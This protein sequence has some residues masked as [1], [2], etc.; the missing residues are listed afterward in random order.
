MFPNIN[1]NDSI[2]DYYLDMKEQGCEWKLIIPEK[3]SPS[4]AIQFS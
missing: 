1:Q 4:G 2:F 3:W